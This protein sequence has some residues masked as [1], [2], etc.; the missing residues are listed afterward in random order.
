MPAGIPN[1]RHAVG[2]KKRILT[3]FV[4]GAL[5]FLPLTAAF[6]DT[7]VTASNDS[8]DTETK[9]GDS[10][11]RNSGSAFVGHQGGGETDFDAEEADDAEAD[12]VEQADIDSTAATNVQEGDNDLDVEQD[13]QSSSG[14]TI[15]GQVFGGVITGNLDADMTNSSSDVEAESGDATSENDFAAFV[16]LSGSSGTAFGADAGAADISNA[17]ATNV[18]EGDNSADVGQQTDAVT[19]DAVGGQIFGGVVSGTTDA[20]LANT[21]EDAEVTSGDADETADS[22]LFTGLAAS[23]ILEFF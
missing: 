23:G 19:G 17:S 1:L 16:G 21:S 10:E 8:E 11:A 14:D 3:L 2:V 6:A 7:D 18:Q 20:V 4:A 15:G 5:G 12:D 13:A 9:S 22:D